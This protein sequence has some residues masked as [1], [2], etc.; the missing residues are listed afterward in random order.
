MPIE[1]ALDGLL[2]IFRVL[3]SLT[4]LEVPGSACGK[5]FRFWDRFTLDE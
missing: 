1:Q 4:N 5:R 2:S 3:G